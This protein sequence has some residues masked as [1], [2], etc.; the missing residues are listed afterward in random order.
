[1]SDRIVVPS[2]KDDRKQLKA[3]ITEMANCIQRAADERESKKDIA[4]SINEKFD[5]PVKAVNKMANTMHKNSY[6]DLQAENE[7]FEL[8]YET[9]ILLKT[10]EDL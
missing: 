10:S 9:L 4:D 1:M 8:L 6:A 7:D 3:M 2:S 5:I